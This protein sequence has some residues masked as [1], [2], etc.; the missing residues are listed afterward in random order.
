MDP[1]TLALILGAAGF[2]KSQLIDRPKEARDRKFESVKA[3]WAPWTGMNP[4][5]VKEADPFGSTIQGAFTGASLGQAAASADALNA[6]TK[7]QTAAAASAAPAAA[8][9]GYSLWGPPGNQFPPIGPPLPPSPYANTVVPIP[10]P[11]RN[12]TGVGY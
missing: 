12:A 8:A 5:P 3:Q 11:M 1:V 9:P 6:Y 7:A 10:I 4:S 2:A